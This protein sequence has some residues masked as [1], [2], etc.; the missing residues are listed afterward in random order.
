MRTTN[1]LLVVIETVKKLDTHPTAQDIFKRAHRRLP[2]ISLATVYRIL[3]RLVEE[4]KLT[5]VAITE[6][7]YEALLDKHFHFVCEKCNK[8]ENISAGD[9]LKAIET[10]LKRKGMTPK[11]Q[12]LIF[13]GLC[14]DCT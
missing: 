8:I 11:R 4:G 14:K 7:R 10:R 13:Y 2:V 1:Q 12:E 5:R 9:H 3:N 6:G